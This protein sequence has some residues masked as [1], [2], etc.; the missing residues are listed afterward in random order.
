MKK[1]PR[2]SKVKTRIYK[3]LTAIDIVILILGL[4]TSAIFASMNFKGKWVLV[5]L[6]FVI[7]TVLL[8][9]DKEGRVYE[10]ILVFFRYILRPKKYGEGKGSVDIESL[11]PYA[12]VGV[13]C[14]ENKDGSFLSV[15]EVEPINMFLMEEYERT[16]YIDAFNSVI[17]MVGA[18]RS[19]FII[20]LS[21]IK[22]FSLEIKAEEERIKKLDR[23]KNLNIINDLE[24]SSRLEVI[25]DRKKL[26]I[27]L[28]DLRLEQSKYYIACIA[29]EEGDAIKAS[30]EIID[31]LSSMKMKSKASMGES[32]QCFINKIYPF[33]KELII[34]PRCI[35][36]NEKQVSYMCIKGYPDN[37]GSGWAASLFDIEET[38]VI[39]HIKGMD[40]TE[41]KKMVDTTIAEVGGQ[42]IVGASSNISREMHAD[43]LKEL[44]I[45]ME[46]GAEIVVDVSIYVSVIENKGSK[47]KYKQAKK[48]I[49]EA[50]FTYSDMTFSQDLAY[51]QTMLTNQAGSKLK[52]KSFSRCMT[53]STVSMSF[54]FV[55]DRF[56]DKGGMLIGENS[57]PVFL[58]AF[59]RDEERVNSN[60]VIIGRTGSGKSYA[61][62]TILTNLATE[63][64]NIFILD[65]E[66]EYSS[67]IKNLGGE[68]LNPSEN[69]IINPFEIIKGI[70]DET[71]LVTDDKYIHLQFLEEFFKVVLPGTSQEVLERL[72]RLISEMY[73]FLNIT[74][75]LENLTSKDYP[76][77]DTLSNFVVEKINGTENELEKER[78]IT[79][80]N[81]LA[82]F[83]TGGSYS[84]LWNGHTN[85]NAC[86]KLKSY[87]FQSLLSGKNTTVC[88]GQMLLVLRLLENEIIKNRERNKLVSP[89]LTSPPTVIFENLGGSQLVTSS[90][91][92]NNIENKR[93][94]RGEVY[95]GKIC[96][97][98]DE[99]HI[100]ID[101][102]HNVSLDFM[103]SLAKRIRKYDGML[104]VITQNIKD[105]SGSVDTLRKTSAIINASQYSLIFSLNPGDIKDLTDLYSKAGEISDI[106]REEILRSKRGRALLIT[107]PTEKT[108]VDILATNKTSKLWEE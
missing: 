49:L 98:I 45:E 83:R 80:Y 51:M 17:K 11:T 13:G 105:F 54:P 64:C 12:K 81:L 44:L 9:E 20:K 10:K 48:K 77:F 8:L 61:A 32:L 52:D 37:V 36:S 100:F 73:K 107:T 6:S 5:V 95:P 38:S 33:Q 90:P 46:S 18:D 25:N 50:G 40:K 78:L 76:T 88:N 65:P 85:F 92:S 19:L 14:V 63:G 42:S 22:D 41:V 24:C 34:K 47:E 106:E 53:S 99:A 56:G 79:I 31:T 103:Y 108:F 74:S 28:N 59:Y 60:M 7:T 72:N 66:G 39:M 30:R 3:S 16:R 101:E 15:V 1:I 2:S 70:P 21:E 97:V 69:S 57:Y 55:S 27:N 67:L 91:R 104:I 93:V 102:K 89:S 84:S 29:K 75:D 68:E 43:S 26:L 58:D 23:D 96:V 4:I 35:E 87:N 62:K 86:G 82:K 71:G 94:S